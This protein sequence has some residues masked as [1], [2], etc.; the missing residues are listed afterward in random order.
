MVARWGMPGRPLARKLTGAAVAVA[1][2]CSLAAC[3]DDSSG[4]DE[5]D[6]SR[7]EGGALSQ[8]QPLTGEPVDGDL[9]TY[10]VVTVKI[11]NTAS[12]AP[13]IGLKTAD[14]ITEELVEGG[15]TRLAATYYLS[16]IHISEPTRPY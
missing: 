12:S 4:G 7:R 3:S 11:D 14:L 16:L 1:L 2:V 15:L 10:P 5:L 6:E 9:P 8:F 13:Q